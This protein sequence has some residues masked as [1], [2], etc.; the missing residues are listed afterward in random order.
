MRYGHHTHT[1][2]RRLENSFQLSTPEIVAIKEA[3]RIVLLRAVS[4]S[5]NRHC[6][7]SFA[8]A[9]TDRARCKNWTRMRHVRFSYRIVIFIECHIHHDSSLNTLVYNFFDQSKSSLKGFFL[10]K[11]SSSKLFYITN[12]HA[13]INTTT[14]AR[15]T[16]HRRLRIHDFF[17]RHYQ[18]LL[19]PTTAP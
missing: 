14:S 9:T 15:Y 8:K 17:P 5:D 1:R 19:T 18:T 6:Q 10:E 3:R 13:S 12:K 16:L 4:E 7:L 2:A 11:G